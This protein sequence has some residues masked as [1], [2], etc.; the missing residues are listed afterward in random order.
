MSSDRTLLHLKASFWRGLDGIRAGL[1]SIPHPRPPSPDFTRTIRTNSVGNGRPGHLALRFYT[2]PDYAEQPASKRIPVI[3]NFH[4]GGFVLGK[5]TD[6]G[7]WAYAILKD[8]GAVFVSVEYRLGPASPF[9]TAVEDGVEA[10][11]YLT[12]KEEELGIDTTRMIITGFSAGGNL[13]FSVPL[14]LHAHLEGLGSEAAAQPT[15]MKNRRTTPRIIA[16]ISWYPILDYRIPRTEKRATSVR[17][18][19]CLSPMFTNLFDDSYLPNTEDKASPFASPVAASD[20]SLMTSLP[21]HIIIY[22]CEWDMLLQEGQDF[23][24]RLKNLGKNVESLIIE[25]VEHAFD[26]MPALKINGKVELHYQAA[27]RV[28]EKVLAEDRGS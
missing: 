28:I 11:L 18:E 10:L 9:P 26:K 12:D 6:D 15:M 1:N 24:R 2:R 27:C 21:S 22:L 23:A 13:A 8:I 5:A 17:P 14:K 25:Q 16:I 19:K 7:R 3:V 4:S 20:E